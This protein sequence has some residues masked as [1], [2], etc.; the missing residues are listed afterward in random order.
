M[1]EADLMMLRW[2]DS[3]LER[4]KLSAEKQDAVF[5]ALMLE[6]YL[7]Y[8]MTPGVD[9]FGKDGSIKRGAVK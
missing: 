9:E 4:A 3:E 7:K 8:K 1:S 5:K 6:F 2:Q